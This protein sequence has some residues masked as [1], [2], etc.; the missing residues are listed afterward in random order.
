MIMTKELRT[1]M[2]FWKEE[3]SF[4]F[5]VGVEKGKP[6]TEKIVL[7]RLEELRSEGELDEVETRDVEFNEIRWE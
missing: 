6:I 5:D 2:V 7:E 3:H 1:I 4:Q